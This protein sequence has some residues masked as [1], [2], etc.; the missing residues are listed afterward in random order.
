MWRRNARAIGWL[1]AI[2]VVLLLPS[3]A[4][5]D[6][7]ISF[8]QVDYYQDGSLGSGVQFSE[9][10]E[11][12]VSY[13][14]GAS[15]EW[16]NVVANPGSLSESWIVQNH[17]L[18]PSSLL[19]SGDSFSSLSYFDLGVSRG[20]DL[21]SLSILVRVDPVPLSIAPSTGDLAIAELGTSQAIINSG[22]PSG[23][24]ALNAPAPTGIDWSALF[25]GVETRWHEGMP[26]VVQEQN[27]CG[28]GAAANSLHWL[29]GQ[30]GFGLQQT[31]Q[32]TQTELAGN[33]GNAN[34]GNWDDTEVQG[35]IQYAKEHNLPIEIHYTG[36]VMLPTNGDYVEPNGNGTAR[37]DGPITWEWLQQEMEKGQDI[38]LMTNTHWV[39]MEG[40]ISWDNIHLFAY[41]DDPFQK[42]AATTAAQ[43][44]TIADRHVWTY[45]SGGSVNIGNG[46][47]VLRAAVA[48]SPVPEPGSLTLMGLGLAALGWRSRRRA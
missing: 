44:K 27:F 29:N 5:A 43:A 19:G 14:P 46:R 2:G 38:E 33:M 36:G 23:V 45:F 20:T 12:G 9:W 48:E 16:I 1:A 28:P 41:R 10:G 25:T 22:V 30:H 15:L 11:F 8:S 40:F 7:E 6:I 18:L 24:L 31:L 47:E 4:D 26:N 34:N 21:S 35:K 39:V 42:G 37:N 13:D 3:S 17:P 32:E